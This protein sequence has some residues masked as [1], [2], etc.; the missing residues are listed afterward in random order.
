MHHDIS[1]SIVA[2][3][4]ITRVQHAIDIGAALFEQPSLVPGMAELVLTQEACEILWS[5]H[6]ELPDC[7]HCL[8]P[9]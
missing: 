3:R 9:I 7:P 1:Y 4:R 2:I 8:V 6:S 5:F